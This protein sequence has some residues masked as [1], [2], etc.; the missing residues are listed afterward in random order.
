LLIANVWDV[1]ILKVWEPQIPHEHAWNILKQTNL[2]S[3]YMHQQ[4]LMFSCQRL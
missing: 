1:K 4:D 3:Q 2:V